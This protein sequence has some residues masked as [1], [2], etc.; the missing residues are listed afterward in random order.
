VLSP[1]HPLSDLDLLS[2]YDDAL[3]DAPSNVTTTTSASVLSLNDAAQVDDDI[4][5]NGSG[6]SWASASVSGRSRSNR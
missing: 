2:D 5:S 3:S 4:R 6:F 1:S